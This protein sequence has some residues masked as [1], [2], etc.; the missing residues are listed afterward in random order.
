MTETL[1]LVPGLLC[2]AIVWE[3]QLEALGGRYN[4]H[5]ADVTGFSSIRGMA[6]ATLK[7]VPGPISVAGHSMGA[8]V[9]LE[10]VRI[11]ADRI[12]RLGLLD[13][14]VDPMTEGEPARR[15]TLV[16]LG[17]REGMR[18]LAEAWLPPMVRPGALDEDPELRRKLYAMVERMSPDIHKRQ[19]K[20]LL[21][22]PGASGVLRTLNCPVLIGCGELDC[23]SPPSQHEAMA[24]LVPG[25]R[26]VLFS[27]SG[28]M[29]PMEAPE[30][31]TQALRHWLEQVPTQMD[32]STN[33]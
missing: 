33:E 18:A 31:V 30:A 14:G 25:A 13:T 7:A 29:A 16:D 21:D 19:I 28:H 3:H 4:V 27:G 24:E 9:A 8:R 32:L 23:W 2:D 26:F 17:A 1:V 15:Q 11:A 12:I 20:A 10:M 5:V 22:R 6:K